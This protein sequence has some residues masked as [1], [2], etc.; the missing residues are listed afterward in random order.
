M[1]QKNSKRIKDF[2]NKTPKFTNSHIA[3]EVDQAISPSNSSAFNCDDLS[4]VIEDILSKR[5]GKPITADTAKTSKK[6]G[7]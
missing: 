4:F 7:F 1:F 6:V 3:T 5:V 2:T